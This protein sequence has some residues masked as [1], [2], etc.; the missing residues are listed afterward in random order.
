MTQKF[1]TC[2]NCLNVNDNGCNTSADC[3]DYTCSCSYIGL[4]VCFKFATKELKFNDMQFEE[5]K[6]EDLKN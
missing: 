3:G 4:C 5:I 6:G 1:Q 2:V